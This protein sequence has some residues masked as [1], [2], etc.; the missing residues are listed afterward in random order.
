MKTLIAM[1]LAALGLASTSAFA[2]AGWEEDFDKGAEQAKKEGKYMIVD[3]S[4]SDWCGWCIKLDKEVFSQKEFKKFAKDNLI[5]VMLDF[6]RSKPQSKKV[7]E[8]NEA[9]MNQHGVRGFPTV[10][11]MSP[12]GEVIGRTGYKAGGPEEYVKHIQEFI[13]AHK[14]KKS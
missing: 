7:R 14:A 10:L 6:P 13:D 3:F 1:V 9:L 5:T 4:G 11:V 8:R 2:A 12:D